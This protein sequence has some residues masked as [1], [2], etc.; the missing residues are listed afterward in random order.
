MEEACLIRIGKNHDKIRIDFQNEVITRESL[1]HDSHANINERMK[2]FTLL[3]AN[4]SW[5]GITSSSHEKQSTHLCGVKER[6]NIFLNRRKLA[7]PLEGREGCQSKLHR[8]EFI[9]MPINSNY[10]YCCHFLQFTGL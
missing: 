7:F 5:Q 2:D 3:I 1:N 8:T 4:E 10:S 9:C 6:D